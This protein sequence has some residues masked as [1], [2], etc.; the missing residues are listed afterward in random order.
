MHSDVGSIKKR[1]TLGHREWEKKVLAPLQY[2]PLGCI[3]IWHKYLYKH[4]KCINTFIGWGT[5]KKCNKKQQYFTLNETKICL[6]WVSK[7]LNTHKNS[8]SFL[9][10]FRLDLAVKSPSKILCLLNSD[11]DSA[12]SRHLLTNQTWFAVC[13]LACVLRSKRYNLNWPCNHQVTA[14]RSWY[15]RRITGQ[16]TERSSAAK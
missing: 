3:W 13:L 1:S 9:C 5:W 6:N 15:A 16:N 7:K 12:C 8:H 11:H 4:I 2:E 10:G 14:M